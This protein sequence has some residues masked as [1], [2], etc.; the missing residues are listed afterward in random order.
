M[1]RQYDD[2]GN[3]TDNDG[4]FWVGADGTHDGAYFYDGSWH[5]SP[6]SSDGGV[7]CETRK[8][9]AVGPGTPIP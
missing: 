5:I 1:A 3:Y 8:S 6:P 2:F 7:I 4:Q 9:S